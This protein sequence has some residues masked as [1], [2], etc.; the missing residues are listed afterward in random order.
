[1]PQDYTKR[2]HNPFGIDSVPLPTHPTPRTRFELYHKSQTLSSSSTNL[3]SGTHWLQILQALILISAVD[4]LNTDFADMWLHS[5]T[6]IRMAIPVRLYEAGDIDGMNLTGFAEKMRAKARDEVEQAE[7]NMTWWMAYALDRSIAVW[8]DRPTTLPEEE[9]TVTLPVLQES[10]ESAGLLG[11]LKGVQTILDVD[12]Y[13]NHPICHQDSL[14]IYIKALKLFNDTHA[15][16]RVYQRQPHTTERYLKAVGFRLL[17]SQAN[18]FRMSIPEQLRKPASTLAMGGQLDR[19][20]LMAMMYS[21]ATS[22]V[23]ANPLLT[24][25]SWDDNIAKMGLMAVR[26]ILNL[27]YDSKLFTRQTTNLADEGYSQRYE[28]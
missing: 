15:F 19:E 18:A 1:M 2:S 13:T 10:Y 20:L 23:L 3:R 8:T 26:A 4:Q 27:I 11:E 5:G 25:E 14:V 22:L 9:I 12:L 7:M 24:V 21:Q 6:V 16:F 17:L 28:L